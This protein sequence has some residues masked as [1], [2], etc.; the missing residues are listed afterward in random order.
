VSKVRESSL[1]V[2]SAASQIAATARRQGATS[3]GLHSATTEIAA[4]VREV[5]ATGKGL[6]GARNE[7]NGRVRQTADLAGSGRQRLGGMERTMQQLVESTGSISSKLAVI[8]EKAD[9][10]T[11]AVTTTQVVDQTTCCRPNAASEA[12]KAGEYGR[13]PLVVAQEA[14]R[15]ADQA[16]VAT[17]GIESMVRLVQGAVPAGVLPTDQSGEGV[18]SGH[19]VFKNAPPIGPPGGGDLRA[20]GGRPGPSWP[21]NSRATWAP[22]AAPGPAARGRPGGALPGGA[23]GPRRLVKRATC[24]AQSRRGA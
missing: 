24:F 11:Q 22:A 6:S 5:S 16:P 19:L 15:L 10:I 2:L 4:A 18:R 9:T 17:L 20:G 13:G 7:A 21:A 12:E 1:Q 23:A 3:Q 14:R 8:R